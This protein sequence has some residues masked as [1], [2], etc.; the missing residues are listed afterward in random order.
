MYS[1]SEDLDFRKYPR[2]SKDQCSVAMPFNVNV[3]CNG[4]LRVQTCEQLLQSTFEI[5]SLD[6]QCPLVPAVAASQDRFAVKN[7][8]NGKYVAAEQFNKTLFQ[9]EL[10]FEMSYP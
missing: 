9:V 10:L 1:A 3:Q 4:E 2:V 5:L 6:E 7:G 8:G